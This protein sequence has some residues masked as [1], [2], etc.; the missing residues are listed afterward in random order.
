MQ[1]IQQEVPHRKLACSE[2]SR[3]H[4]M[5]TESN[6]VV[7]TDSESATDNQCGHC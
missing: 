6:G 7:Y 4:P 3:F 2:S 1:P 5:V